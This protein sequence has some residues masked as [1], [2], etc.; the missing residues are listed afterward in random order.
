MTNTYPMLPTMLLWSSA[1]WRDSL[2]RIFLWRKRFT[3]KKSRDRDKVAVMPLATS[4]IPK[5]VLPSENWSSRQ[6]TSQQL[7]PLPTV[8]KDLHL[9]KASHSTILQAFGRPLSQMQRRQE[10]GPGI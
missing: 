2:A 8:W 4:Q 9:V 6:M 5:S 3:R 7:L 1:F 10:S